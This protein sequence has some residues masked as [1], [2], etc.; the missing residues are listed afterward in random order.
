MGDGTFQVELENLSSIYDRIQAKLGE[1]VVGNQAL[2]ELIF[3]ALMSR[4]HILV[5]GVPG[6]AKTTLVKAIAHL[7][8]C[9]FARIQCAVDTQPADIIGVRI[10]NQERR[11]FE[12]KKG[13]IFSNIL[14]I[15]EINR[16]TPKSQSAFIEA[17]SERQVTID[18]IT[19]TLPE[20][21]FVLA[22]Q[23]PYEYEG[24]FPLI[25]AQKDRFMLSHVLS[26]LDS[27]DELE[28]IKREHT[29]Q[30]EWEAY[31][32]RLTPLLSGNDIT[33]ITMG[34]SPI[35]MEEP[36]LRYIRDL[37]LAS[38]TH[39]DVQLGVSARASIA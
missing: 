2:V 38:R 20:P 15:D 34:F 28:I 10:Y 3:I 12:L 22:T 25:E 35:R 29:G 37:V 11:E 33:R 8:G 17:M 36:I 23:N 27:D 4:G 30:L 26:H 6:T 19:S 14:L 21:F 18:G 16:I 13:P 9:Q 39:S 31:T 1:F 5:E 7:S 32:E 24:T